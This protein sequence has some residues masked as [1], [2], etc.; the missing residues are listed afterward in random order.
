[1]KKIKLFALAAFAML[2]INTFAAEI[3]TKFAG[4]NGVMYQVS[5]EYTPANPGAGTD[6]IPGEVI[7]V[8]YSQSATADAVTI[9]ST[10]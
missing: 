9:P 6:A 8:A 7:V 10:I 4:A 3:G 1:M 2:S 5:K